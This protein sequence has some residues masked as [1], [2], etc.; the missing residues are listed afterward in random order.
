MKQNY[1]DKLGMEWWVREEINEYSHVRQIILILYFGVKTP[2][3][4][5]M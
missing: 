3:L 4:S 5:V 2:A 1:T